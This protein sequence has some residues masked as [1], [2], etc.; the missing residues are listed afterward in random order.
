MILVPFEKTRFLGRT[1]YPYFYSYVNN[2]HFLVFWTDGQTD[3]WTEKIDWRGLGKHTCCAWAV[4]TFFCCLRK[5]PPT[6]P[7]FAGVVQEFG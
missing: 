3:G 1:P 2:L 6:H 7:H 5:G 4:G